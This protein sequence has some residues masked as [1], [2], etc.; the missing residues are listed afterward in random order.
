MDQ[1][2]RDVTYGWRGLWRDRAFALTTVAT[3]GVALALVTVVFAIF[4]AYVLRPYAV[5]DPY[6]LYE[7]RWRSQNASGRLFRSSDYEELRK[8]PELFEDVIAERNRPVAFETRSIV[9][10]FV[11]GNYFE[12][13]GGRMHL[14][15]QLAPFDAS[16]PGSAPVVVLSHKAWTTLFEGD[17]SVIGREIRLNDQ[18]VTV[19]G[20]AAKEFFGMNDTPPDLWI[21]MTMHGEIIKQDLFGVNQPRELALVGR[22]RAG[23]T[24]A[25]AEAALTPLL[26]DMVDQTDSVR[27]VLLPQATPAPL[28]LELMVV[29]SPVLATFALVLLAASANVTNVMLARANVRQREIGIR[30]SIGASRGRVVRQLLTEGMLISVIAGAVGIVLGSLV[31]RTGLSVFFLSLPSAAGLT[32]VV[33]LDFDYRVFGFT[34]LVAGMTTILFALTPALHATRVTLTGALR[35]EMSGTVRGS[36]LRNF[37]V[38]SQVTVSL[39]LLIGAA[40]L[41]RNGSAI[42]ATDLGLQTGGVISLNQDTP[43]ENLMTQAATVLANEPRVSHVAATSHTPLHGQ[44]PKMPLRATSE[45][46]IVVTSYMFVSPEYFPTVNIPILRGRPFSADEAQSEAQVGIL[47]AAAARSLWPNE[48]PIGKTIQVWITPEARPDLMTKRELVSTADVARQSS[49]VTVIGVVA[50]VVSGIIYEG[51]DQSHLY[52]PTSV[53]A[54]HAKSLLVRARSIQDLRPEGLQA[55]LQR[56]HPNPLAFD[57]MTLDDAVAMQKFPLMVT[58][59][60]GLVLSGVALALSVSGLYGV[61]THSVSQ[62]TREI[63]IR[64]ALGATSAAVVRMLMA[65]SGRLV[66]LGAGVGLIFSLGVLAVVRA[67]LVKLDNLSPLD[68]CA[69]TA[70]AILV[71]AASAVATYYPARRASYIEP[72]VTLRSD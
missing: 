46:A 61:V 10:A 37:L 16:I 60:I 40:T 30:L 49:T 69:V 47:S 55:L 2:I 63:G 34:F 41:V 13:L 14:G 22:L 11:S 39:V 62:R 44:L 53:G 29:V 42:E 5:R 65:Q 50:D 45:S 7:V 27:G 52:L 23:T 35:G 32:R 54:Q 17:T 59:W 33:P 1:F 72:S 8:K 3:L 48:D 18:V 21:P 19:V 64:M 6:S 58:S 70:S 67:L 25:Q 15:R 28:T 20:I 43:G 36:T 51:R 68:A 31:I 24:A 38:A 66:A 9:A 71:A 12:S 56:V 4:N 26:P 57:A